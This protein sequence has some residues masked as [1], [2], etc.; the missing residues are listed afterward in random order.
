MAERK[1][2][3]KIKCLISENGGDSTSKEFMDFFGEHGIKREFSVANTPHKNKV[4]KRNNIT[5]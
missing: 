3:L 4:T 2:Y 1:T 5:V